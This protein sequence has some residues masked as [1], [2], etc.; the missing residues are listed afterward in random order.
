MD[1]DQ[2]KESFE[3]NPLSGEIISAQCSLTQDKPYINIHPVLIFP[4]KDVPTAKIDSFSD[5]KGYIMSKSI[6]F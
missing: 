4:V 3:F 6:T 1:T 5:D 2:P